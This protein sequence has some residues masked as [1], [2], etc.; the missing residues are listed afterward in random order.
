M[1][2]SIGKTNGSAGGRSREG[3]SVEGAAEGPSEPFRSGSDSEPLVDARSPEDLR[4]S[5]S[6]K[7]V[8]GPS[9]PRVRHN[10]TV[11]S[12]ALRTQNEAA[13]EEVKAQGQKME[14]EQMQVLLKS[15]KAE[16]SILNATGR[17]QDGRVK[18]LNS[19]IGELQRLLQK[20]TA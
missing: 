4:R 19:Q 11:D 5:R 12:K 7:F 10:A 13:W 20:Q 6:E 9:S 8:N 16:Q 3:G 14:P 15:L 18:A 1:T 2:R 17:D